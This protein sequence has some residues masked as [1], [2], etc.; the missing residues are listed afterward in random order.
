LLIN[1]LKPGQSPD[2]GLMQLDGTRQVTP[3]LQSPAV[4]RVADV[5][6]DGKWMVYESDESS[7]SEIYVR[8]FPDTNSGKW[9][10]S[11]AGG[12][13]PL[14]APSG[15]EIFYV[16]SNGFL[17]AVPVQTTPTFKAGHPVKLFEARNIATLASARFYDVSRDGQRFVMIKELAA[18]PGA[19]PVSSGPT[20]VV[21]VNWPEELKAAIV[22]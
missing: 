19:Q 7:K 6:S 18:P 22:K 12:S 4:E 5:S 21:V 11:I 13:K 3:V 8:P 16:D 20:F 1:E 15:K 14:W 10:A 17:M 2:I 9:Q